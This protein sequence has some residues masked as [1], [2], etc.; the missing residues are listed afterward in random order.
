MAKQQS[1]KYSY[2]EWIEQVRPD[3]RNTDQLTLM[4]GYIGQ[5]SENGHVRVYSDESLNHF[6]EVPEDAIVFAVKLSPTESS[7]GG[8]KLWLRSDA[9]MT[10]GDPKA[11]NRPKSTFLEGDLMQ[12][13][14]TQYGGGY[15]QTG[16]VG[17]YGGQPEVAAPGGQVMASI[18]CP[19]VI[20]CPPTQ[21]LVC[22]IQSRYCPIPTRFC[23]IPTKFCPIQTRACPI[24]TR[25]CPI[26]TRACH[27]TVTTRTI[28]TET[29]PT[30]PIGGPVVQPGGIMGGQVDPTY[31]GGYYGTF[32]P[33]MM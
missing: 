16:G 33:Y 28:F 8:S 9:V 15:D 23:P 12:Q 3:L 7:L 5:S 26:P 13:Y 24:P 6:V 17:A 14:G 11:A 18:Q 25:A 31:M 22:P 32:N 21:P 19:S 20:L 30:G 29:I 10:Y 1:T 27:Y 2:D 4:Q